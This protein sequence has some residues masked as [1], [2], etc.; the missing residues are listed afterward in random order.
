MLEVTKS[1][2]KKGQKV[3]KWLKKKVP[4]KGWQSVKMAQKKK[5]NQRPPA[6][7]K[8]S[9]MAQKAP[10]NPVFHPSPPLS[11]HVPNLWLFGRF[12]LFFFVNFC[13]FCLCSFPILG[14][15]WAPFTQKCPIFP[16]APPLKVPNLPQ[17]PKKWWIS[18]EF[19]L[20][21]GNFPPILK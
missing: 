11:P 19:P 21:S 1:A 10:K 5:V 6:W 16:Q 17:I 13:Y 15:I 7:P 18:P 12:S 20:K 9:K 14:L 3:T 4:K 2:K 8:T